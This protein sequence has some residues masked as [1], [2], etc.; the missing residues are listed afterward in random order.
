MIQQIE[1]DLV[2]KDA[3]TEWNQLREMEEFL[4]LQKLEL[5]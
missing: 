2:D 1:I 4:K 5:L 3:D